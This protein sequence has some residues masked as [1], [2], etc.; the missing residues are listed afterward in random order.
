[1]SSRPIYELAFALEA[2]RDQ[3]LEQ[4]D[5]LRKAFCLSEETRRELQEKAY[6]GLLDHWEDTGQPE[7]WRLGRAICQMQ[8]EEFDSKVWEEERR[9]KKEKSE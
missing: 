5:Y 1:M 2:E 7:L 9:K 6:E 3:L 8:G 4:C